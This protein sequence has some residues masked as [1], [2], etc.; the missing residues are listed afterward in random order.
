MECRKFPEG[1]LAVT[2]MAFKWISRVR[3]GVWTHSKS[4]KGL[5]GTRQLHFSKKTPAGTLALSNTDEIT[6]A[7]HR[8]RRKVR[9][10]RDKKEQARGRNRSEKR[11]VLEKEKKKREADPSQGGVLLGVATPTLLWAAHL[12]L[13]Q[14]L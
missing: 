9:K 5:R 2:A 13:S 3:S 4:L 7:E 14:K 1:F 6:I 8:N 10:K 11:K 12:G